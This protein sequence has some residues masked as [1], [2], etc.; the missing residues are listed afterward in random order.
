MARNVVRTV[1]WRLTCLDALEAAEAAA[2]LLGPFADLGAALQ[3]GRPDSA[4]IRGAPGLRQPPA[5]G[6]RPRA[7][8]S[9]EFPRPASGRLP[10]LGLLSGQEDP[11][12]T[13]GAP[14]APSGRRPARRALSVAEAAAGDAGSAGAGSAAR[15]RPWSGAVCAWPPVPRSRNSG[16]SPPSLQLILAALR[17]QAKRMLSGSLGLGLLLATADWPRH[18]GLYSWPL[19]ACGQSAAIFLTKSPRVWSGLESRG[20][21]GLA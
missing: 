19:E 9:P 8:P 3:S 15:W 6:L 17:A 14:G 21:A 12:R 20:P 13:P 18:R 7:T 10:A 1:G 11:G 4:W 16:A 2:S 5:P